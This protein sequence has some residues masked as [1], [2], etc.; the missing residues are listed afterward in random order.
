MELLQL[1]DKFTQPS[2]LKPLQKHYTNPTTLHT[3]SATVRPL[4]QQYG[5]LS[6]VVRH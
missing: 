2:E 4:R 5:L 6:A 3:P 1:A